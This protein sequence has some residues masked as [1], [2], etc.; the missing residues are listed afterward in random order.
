MAS[1]SL[2]ALNASSGY[3]SLAAASAGVKPN[4][5][6]PRPMS[7]TAPAPC[8]ISRRVAENPTSVMSIISKACTRTSQRLQ[9]IH[10]RVDFLFGQDPV[11][12]E[13][14]HHGQ[15]IAQGFIVDNGDEILALGILA[16]DVD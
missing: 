9:E 12:S 11:A 3:L 15:R 6:L 5:R 10:H 14:R 2:L 4:G 16:L 8:R 7:A 13:R 1:A